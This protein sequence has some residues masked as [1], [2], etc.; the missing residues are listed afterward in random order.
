MNNGMTNDKES[1]IT[2]SPFNDISL[3]QTRLI[4]ATTT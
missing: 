1:D 2:P 4:I 3:G